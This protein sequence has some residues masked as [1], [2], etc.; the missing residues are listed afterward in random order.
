MKRSN[1][2]LRFLYFLMLTAAFLVIVNVFLVTIGKIHIRSNTSLE[3][4]VQS[5]SNVEERIFA[6]RGNIYDSNGSIVAQDVKTYDIICYLDPDRLSSS[7]EV[8][9]VDNPSFAASVLAPIL[10]MDANE[11]Y[12]LLVNNKSLYQIELGAKG[13]N[14]S[15]EQKKQIEAIEGLHGIDFR[16]SYKRYYPYGETFSPQLVGFAQSDNTGKLIGKLGIESYLND[17]LSGT[18]GYHSYQRDKY[19][20]ILPGMF[21][22]TINAVNGYDVY[23]TLDVSIQEALNSALATTIEAKNASRA[24]AAV[25][26][27]KTGKILAWG[28]TPSFDP[29][30]LLQDD[31]QVNYGAQLAYEPGSVMKSVIYSAAMDMGVYDGEQ[32]FDSSPYCYTA[33]SGRTYAGDQL[34]C[35]YNVSRLDWG[36][37]PLDYGLIY[38]SNVATATLL[39]QYVGIDNYRN[40]LE[41]YHLYQKVNTDGI[42]EVSGYTNYGLSPVDDITATYGQGSSTTMLQLLQA[43][44]AI[45]GNGEMIKPYLI[46][47]IVDPNTDTV[48]YQGSRKVV[49]TPISKDTAKQMQDLLRRVV[50]EPDGTCRHYAAKTVEVMGKTGTSEIPLD[51][52]YA[53]DENI[54]S[55][56]LGFPYEDPEYMVYFAYVSPETVYFNYDIKPIPDLIDR[57]ALLENLTF[58][59]NEEGED[60]KYIERH[61]MPN[62]L[63]KNINEARQTLENM[64]LKVIEISDGSHVID[65]LPKEK[66]D[67]YTYQRVFLLSDGNVITV[68]DFTGWTRREV[69][70]FWNLSHV[71]IKMDGF[72]VAYEQSLAPGTVLQSGDEIV[73]RFKDINQKE[74]QAR[75]PVEEIAESDD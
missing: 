47:K 53:E 69:I 49:S 51:G 18:D 1:N 38:S 40:Y 66:E 36:W 70:D 8:A 13:R 26:E 37:I 17:E 2:K 9:F 58:N 11:I 54:I 48:V 31:V 64:D 20:Y 44:T 55:C 4:Y 19:G 33:T 62:L 16:N 32:G 57:I 3:N 71:S 46:D 39:S 73:I 67:V 68:P 24:W 15:E 10:D 42:D 74:E 21:D 45:F 25:V 56:M 30:N 52:G 22:E 60:Q 28:Q 27:I 43:Y 72:G 23:L 75:E 12:S 63:S 61:E 14:L 29:N 35:I 6:S 7:D 65:Q 50:A 59:G 5:V 34:G 41:R